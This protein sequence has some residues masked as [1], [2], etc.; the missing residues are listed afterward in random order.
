[1]GAVMAKAKRKARAISKA[2][3]V[4]QRAPTLQEQLDEAAR[5]ASRREEEAAVAQA[6]LEQLRGQYIQ[7]REHLAVSISHTRRIAGE[8][9]ILRAVIN[10][11]RRKL[12]AATR[13]TA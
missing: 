1:M 8:K 5:Y 12:A 2:R 9:E 13:E 11:L 4:R 6:A 3:R 7:L 10:D